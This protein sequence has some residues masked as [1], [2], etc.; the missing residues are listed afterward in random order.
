[1]NHL[2]SEDPTRY[3]VGCQFLV[4][5]SLFLA[6]LVLA[7][8]PDDLAVVRTLSLVFVQVHTSHLF[9]IYLAIYVVVLPEGPKKG[10]SANTRREEIQYVCS[11]YSAVLSPVGK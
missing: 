5:H 10:E 4:W 2:E 11:P 1:M 7:W 8:L 3:R 6:F 9:S